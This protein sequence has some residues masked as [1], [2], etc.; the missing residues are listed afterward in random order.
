MLH[1]KN[2]DT[3]LQDDTEPESAHEYATFA[4]LGHKK[5]VAPPLGYEDQ[6]GL[7]LWSQAWRK[8]KLRCL[9]DGRFTNVPGNSVYFGV[10]SSSDAI[11][12]RTQ[13]SRDMNYRHRI[14]L[15]K[16]WNTI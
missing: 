11:P 6:S 16:S 10:I 3:K 4:D 13:S 12:T 1:K 9:A 15:I 2:E 5:Q 14:G 7:I 8:K